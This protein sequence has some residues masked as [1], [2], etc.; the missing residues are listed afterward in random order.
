MDGWQVSYEWPAA[1][2]YHPDMFMMPVDLGKM[3]VY[4]G[5]VGWETIKWFRDHKFELIAVDPDEQREF[6]PANMMILEPGKVI[7]HAGAKKTIAKVRKAGV[8]VI[9]VPYT[10]GLNMG[11]GIY[12]CTIQMMRDRGPKLEDIK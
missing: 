7:M 3:L 6:I 4:P 1:G 10:E 5:M 2:T 8:E 12:C 11:G 9:D